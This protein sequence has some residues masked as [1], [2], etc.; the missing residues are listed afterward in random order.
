MVFR[1]FAWIKN[2]EDFVASRSPL[3][4]VLSAWGGSC[5]SSNPDAGHQWSILSTF[6]P[7]YEVASREASCTDCI[8]SVRKI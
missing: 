4:S 3:S 2:H 6:T 8:L 5:S 1:F 7:H